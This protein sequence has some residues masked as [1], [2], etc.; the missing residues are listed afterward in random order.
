MKAEWEQLNADPQKPLISRANDELYLPG[1]TFKMVTASAALQNGWG[2]EDM[3]EPPRLDLPLTNDTLSNF[4]NEFCAGGAKRVTMFEAFTSS[5]NVIFA[6]VG[7]KLGAQKLPTRRRR[8]A[9]VPRSADQ[10]GVHL[11][12]D[13]VRDPVPDGSLP[14]AELLEGNDPLVAI[15]A[16]GQDNDLTNPLQMGLVGPRRSRTVAR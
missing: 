6:E 15:S 14:D 5:C 11:E 16:I 7:L 1:S 9:S 4:G 12:D 10:D 13:P 2:S 8:S 3:A